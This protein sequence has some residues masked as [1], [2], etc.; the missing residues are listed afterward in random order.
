MTE[1]KNKFLD[2]SFQILQRFEKELKLVEYKQGMRMQMRRKYAF[3]QGSAQQ[4][5]DW[6][7]L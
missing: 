3:V 6:G 5:K 4:S 2:M 1:K 7:G